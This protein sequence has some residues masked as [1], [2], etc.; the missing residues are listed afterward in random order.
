[1]L[2]ASSLHEGFLAAG[3]YED[4]Q[5]LREALFLLLSEPTP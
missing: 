3:E 2:A 5:A 4:T 1:V